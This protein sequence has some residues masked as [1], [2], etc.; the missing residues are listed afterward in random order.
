MRSG[1]GYCLASPIPIFPPLPVPAGQREQ[2]ENLQTRLFPSFPVLRAPAGSRTPGASSPWCF[3]HL[4]NHGAK[5]GTELSRRALDVQ[6]TRASSAFP[7]PFIFPHPLLPEPSS[8]ASSPA[9]PRT[10]PS[11]FPACGRGTVQGRPRWCQLRV[12]GPHGVLWGP[13]GTSPWPWGCGDARTATSP[14][15]IPKGAA[16]PQHHEPGHHRAPSPFSTSWGS[17]I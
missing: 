12:P 11:L 5:S 4:A 13:P 10:H 2:G 3:V 15:S 8:P 6:M 7:P 9:P 17:A 16:V 1:A 14:L